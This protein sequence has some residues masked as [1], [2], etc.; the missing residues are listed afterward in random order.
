MGN[1]K[2]FFA[3]EFFFPIRRKKFRFAYCRRRLSCQLVFNNKRFSLGL[4]SPH[5]ACSLQ[6]RWDQQ[7]GAAMAQTNT[8][9][10]EIHFSL[11]SDEELILAIGQGQEGASE[12]LAGRYYQ[13]VLNTCGQYFALWEDAR[14]A[15]Q[16]VFV[17]VFGERKVLQFRGEAQFWTWLY[18]VVLN[19][20]KTRRA[21]HQKNARL[22]MLVGGMPGETW[23]QGAVCALATPEEEYSRGQDRARLDGLL[24]RLP[25]KYREIIRL[26]CLEE[27]SYRDAARRLKIPTGHLG[28]RLMRGKSLLTKLHRLARPGTGL[29]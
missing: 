8:A 11:R 24:Q 14:D 1:G 18:R 25:K 2:D 17:K 28:V 7:E 23:P 26:I 29:N 6:N 21:R 3:P 12:E 22:V 15:A 10:P 20:C 27:Y 9:A 13:K 4:W 19:T 5:L 16:E